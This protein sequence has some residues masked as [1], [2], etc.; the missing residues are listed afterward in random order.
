MTDDF[1]PEAD[2]TEQRQEVAADGS[3]LR[4]EVDKPS[5]AEEADVLEQAQVLPDDEI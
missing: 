1:V 4:A 2:A 3:D 5:E